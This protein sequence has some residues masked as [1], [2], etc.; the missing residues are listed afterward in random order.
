MSYFGFMVSNKFWNYN[1]VK[2]CF[3]IILFQSVYGLTTTA[4]ILFLVVLVYGRLKDNLISYS[5][6][7]V[8]TGENE[9]TEIQDVRTVSVVHLG[10]PEVR[11][12]R[13][14]KTNTHTPQCCHFSKSHKSLLHIWFV[15]HDIISKLIFNH[16]FARKDYSFLLYMNT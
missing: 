3:I 6:H 12:T 9:I 13:K 14:H 2:N 5:R 1:I 8:V 10:S 16:N 11:N 7:Y 15:A 4:F